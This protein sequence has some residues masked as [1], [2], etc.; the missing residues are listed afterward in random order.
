MG[1]TEEH[2]VDVLHT[3]SEQRIT[4]FLD[5]L[6]TVKSARVPLTQDLQQDAKFKAHQVA[7]AKQQ[8]KDQLKKDESLR[9][10]IKRRKIR[11]K[12]RKD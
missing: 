8:A 7:L 2:S 6:K 4:G 3:E 11:D 9:Q 10:R 12:N 5:R 1:Q